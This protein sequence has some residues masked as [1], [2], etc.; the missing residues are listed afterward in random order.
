MI[1]GLSTQKEKKVTAPIF[2]L[3]T[4]GAV[5]SDGFAPEFLTAHDGK[6][7]ALQMQHVDF[8]Q[9][10]R[11]CEDFEDFRLLRGGYVVGIPKT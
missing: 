2:D 9:G 4:V 11:P 1:P 6:R 8:V 10:G 5:Y 7:K 3:A